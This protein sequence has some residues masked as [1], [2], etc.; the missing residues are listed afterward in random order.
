MEGLHWLWFSCLDFCHDC[1]TEPMCSACK[2]LSLFMS[3]WLVWV[4][5]CALSFGLSLQPTGD[6]LLTPTR[7]Y[8]HALLPIIRSGCVKAFAHIT[9]GG[10]LENI[11]RVLPQKFGVDLGKLV[12]W[13][14][15][16]HPQQSAVDLDKLT[17][18]N[19]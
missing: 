14:A 5:V 10:L 11:P 13:K 9:G 6:L 4:S 19:F 1:M 17:R 12:C 8:S 16:Q 7:I 3:E 18:G 15:S 2:T